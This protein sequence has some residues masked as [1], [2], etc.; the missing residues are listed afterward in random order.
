MYAIRSYYD[1][2]PVICHRLASGQIRTN[3]DDADRRLGSKPGLFYGSLLN[4]RAM[5]GSGLISAGSGVEFLLCGWLNFIIRQ[6]T[7]RG[8]I[9]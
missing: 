3:Q 5:A 7:T 8:E 9:V 2:W 1:V 6:I 4:Q